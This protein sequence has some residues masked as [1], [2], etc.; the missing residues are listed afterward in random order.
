MFGL[1][2]DGW[3]NQGAKSHERSTAHSA[4]IA[5]FL[6]SSVAEFADMFA[7][8]QLLVAKWVFA[9]HVMTQRNN[10]TKEESDL[11]FVVVAAAWTA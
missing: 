5:E 6:S 7:L 10:D 1:F 4:P 9:L 3:F 11:P 8:D 2:D